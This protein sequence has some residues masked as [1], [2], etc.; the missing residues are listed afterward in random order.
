[1]LTRL[2]YCDS[3]P[4]LSSTGNLGKQVFLLNSTFDP[5]YTNSGH[6]PLYRD[7]Y[8]AIYDQYAVVECNITIKIVN[9]G[10]VPIQCGMV[11]D[12]DVTT[13]TN[14]NVLMEQNNGQH[15]LI[16]ALTGSLSS[17]TFTY[18][19]SC[20]KVLG[21]D[22]FASQTYKT[23]VGSNPSE[24]STM[25]V[26]VQSIDLASSVTTYIQVE[27]DQLVLWTELATPSVS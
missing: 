3:V 22:P 24:L 5:D 13:S 1:M 25:T 21:I 7:T 19:W 23:A 26:W 8:A 17:G 9:T 2:R 10:T 6:Q 4:L 12:D 27:I 14:Y 18:K 11:I 15:K 20:Q 16:P